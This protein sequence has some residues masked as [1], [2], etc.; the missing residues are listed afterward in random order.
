MN[1]HDNQYLVRLVC[2]RGNEELFGLAIYATKTRHAMSI[3]RKLLEGS[4]YS[5]YP[6]DGR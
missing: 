2:K 1:K 4:G 3:A 5:A 6:L